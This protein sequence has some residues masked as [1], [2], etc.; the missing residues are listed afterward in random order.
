M[1]KKIS[2]LEIEEY[3]KEYKNGMIC[4]EIANKYNRHE[5]TILRALKRLGIYQNNMHYYTEEEKENISID[6]KNGMRPKD[7]GDKYNINPATIIRLLQSLNIYENSTNRW[8]ENEIGYLKENYSSMNWEEILITLARHKKDDII[9]KASNLNLRR[10]CFFWDDKDIEILK[11]NYNENTSIK[12]ISKLLNNKFTYDSI[13]TKAYFLGLQK[14]FPWTDVEIKILKNNYEKI[15]LDEIQKLIP[16]RNRNSIIAYANRRLGLVSVLTWRD[17]DIQFIRDNWTF[18]SDIDMSK[19]LNRTFRSVKAKRENM[20][21][22]RLPE[23]GVYDSLSEYIRK[24][25]KQWRTDSIRNCNFQ[26][27][28]TGQRFKAIHHIYGFNLI[29]KETLSLL[30]IDIK[31]NFNDYNDEELKMITDKFFKIQAT[32]P[33]GMCL[34]EDIHKLFHSVYGYGNNTNEQ[35]FEFEK[36]YK[37]GKYNDLLHA[38]SS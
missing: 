3:A 23:K 36:D 12:D 5:S 29:L 28:L 25:N 21:L 26:C 22:L 1:G 34:R 37:D 9:H 35:W 31:D 32:Y 8:T 13:N 38:K 6:Y 33:L 17:E 30:D 15:S 19:I 18:M 16:N 20:R 14:V 7:I 2:E 24:R 11:E 10:D 4:S 27:Y